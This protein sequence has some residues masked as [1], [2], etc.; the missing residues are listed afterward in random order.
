MT[1]MNYDKLRFSLARLEEQYDNYLH[2][3]ASLSRLNK[4]AVIESTIQRFEVCFDTMWKAL[5]RHLSEEIGIPDVPNGPKL[6]FRLAYEN[7]L[8][9][10]P[11]QDWFRYNSARID[12][13]HDYDGEKAQACVELVGDFISDTIGLYQTMTGETWA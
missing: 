6:I 8:I 13:S 4:E 5:G 12:T 3:D 9:S 7:G 1:G 11:S 10:E 2:L